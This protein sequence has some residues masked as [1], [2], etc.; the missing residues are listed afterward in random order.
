MLK[1]TMAALH[2]LEQHHFQ[3]AVLSQRA[4][5]RAFADVLGRLCEQLD[6]PDL[7][8]IPARKQSQTQPTQRHIPQKRNW[9]KQTNENETESYSQDYLKASRLASNKAARQCRK[10]CAVVI[11]VTGCKCPQRRAHLYYAF[12]LAAVIMQSMSQHLPSLL[13]VDDDPKLRDLLRRYLTEQQFDVSLAADSLAMGKLLVKQRFDLI[14]LD[15]MLPGEDGLSILR[16]LRGANDSTPVILL[17]A[18]GED[19][20]R[21]IGLE[22]GADDYLAKPFN[23]RELVARI[24]AVLRRRPAE[25][26]PGVPETGEVLFGEFRLSLATRTL[27]KG[28]DAVQLTTGEFALLKVFVRN[29]KVPMAREKLMH[30]ARGR[31]YE[32]FDRSLDVQVSRLRKLIE[33]D[34]SKPHF[35]Q[36]VWGIGYV[37]MPEGS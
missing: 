4:S 31:D 18:K 22:M 10:L 3:G 13:V 21:I 23:P 1:L 33:I 24:H 14:V 20:D 12:L 16:R 35:I 9:Q 19:I 17:T 15:L 30:L 27:F 2:S 11:H 29:P 8:P 7:E 25:V 5:A 34:P 36:T 32:N 37:F 26:A 28:S 6:L